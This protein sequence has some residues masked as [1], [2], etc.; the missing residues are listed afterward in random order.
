VKKDSR[1]DRGI[2]EGI[3][4]RALEASRRGECFARISR[5]GRRR[6]GLAVR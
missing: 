1:F 6:V 4:E 5:A 2:S 3:R